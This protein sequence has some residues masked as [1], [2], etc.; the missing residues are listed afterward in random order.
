MH[1]PIYRSER[2][3][4]RKD[5]ARSDSGEVGDPVIDFIE[6][7]KSAL[8]QYAGDVSLSVRS[9]EGI[10]TSEGP[11]DTCAIDL[12]K[13]EYYLHRRFWDGAYGGSE[14]KLLFGAFHEIEHFRELRD[15]L[16]EKDGLEVWRKLQKKKENRRRYHILD[17]SFGDVKVNNTVVS[18]VPVMAGARE[19]LYRD[20]LFSER[21]LTGL[22]KHL[23]FA[24]VLNCEMQVPGETWT[25]DP[26][27]REAFE[28]LKAIHGR[29]SGRPIL[30]YA[31][32]PDVSMRDRLAVQDALIEPVY[33]KFFEED[34]RKKKEE[35]KGQES[36]GGSGEPGEN[37]GD[38]RSDSTTGKPDV[39]PENKP[40][41]SPES[42]SRSSDGNMGKNESI[43]G[44][45]IGENGANPENPEDF[46]RKEYDE[47]FERYPE[48]I[49]EADLNRA[50]EEEIERQQD[51]ARR[52]AGADAFDAYARSRGVSP[53]DLRNYMQFRDSLERIVDP[54]TNEPVV[55]EI[56]ELFE[57]IIAKRLKRMPEPKYSLP[58]GDE[59]EFP[60]EA[61]VRTRA[62]ESEPD[63]WS[64]TEFHEKEGNFVGDFDVILV[65]DTSTSMAEN[66]GKKRDEQRKGLV[67]VMEALSEFSERLEKK[68]SR[69]RHDLHVRNGMWVFGSS[70]ECVKPL[71]EELMEKDR[72]VLYKRLGSMSGSTKDFLVLEA[73][74]E[75]LTEDEIDRM[76]E[77]KLKKIVILMTDGDSDKVSRV[78][79]ELKKLRD[80]GVIV[81]GVGITADGKSAETT[82]APNAML[83]ENAGDLAP[84]LAG[85]L[86]E[87]LRDL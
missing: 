47:Y 28:K 27:V 16:R 81:I 10:L 20:D 62:G 75:A 77:G 69:L 45:P 39:E 82:Y 44:E 65:G 35:Q 60:A 48:T 19:G 56:R 6:R 46:F 42:P 29:K 2:G 22:P 49:P 50:V 85:L 40:Q 23:Q 11:L 41:T 33:E 74:V 58:E 67:L 63:V 80:A 55:D 7:N 36:S 9:A 21:D 72:V 12:E 86:K 78:Q 24:H 37:G 87:H 1:E 34:V 3:T 83:C 4:D 73:L 84:V 52:N 14:E 53:E 18:R 31:T 54:E 38:S 25:V 30:G 13:G 61:V 32:R 71:S 68:R 43:P 66:G 15:L 8:T 70:A 79:E 57:R 5:T 64:D 76:R 26:D 17:N 51:E 59:L